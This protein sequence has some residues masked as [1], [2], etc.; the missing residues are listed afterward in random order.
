MLLSEA[1]PASFAGGGSGLGL[2]GPFD[3]ALDLDAVLLHVTVDGHARHAQEDGGLRGRAARLGQC[4]AQSA[5][6]V[7]HA[8]TVTPCYIRVKTFALWTYGG[9]VR[10]VS[11]PSSKGVTDDAHDMAMQVLRYANGQKVADAL[12]SHGYSVTRMT[13]NRWAR[14]GEMPGIARRMILH[15]FGHGPDV[16]KAPP[17]DWARE[18]EQRLTAAILASHPVQAL[19]EESAH[20]GVEQ[21]LGPQPPAAPAP[22]KQGPQRARAARR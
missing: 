12:T 14:G 2:C 5:L 1:I 9:Y 18:M 15:L 6:L 8:P 22:D 4:L 17:P 7:C 13:V 19:A 16:T 20:Y 10:N 21:T 11:D 3:D